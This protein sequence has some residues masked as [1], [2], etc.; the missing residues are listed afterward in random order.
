M[1]LFEKS[2]SDLVRRFDEIAELVAEARRCR[3]FGYPTCVVNRNLF[4][5]LHQDRCFLRR[6]ET[7]RGSF[8]ASFGASPFEPML[9][10]PMPE[11]VVVPPEL[12]AGP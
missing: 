6:G 8:V 12:L 5:G 3:M 4:A 7:D 10:R 11:Y 9:G 2:P 1:P